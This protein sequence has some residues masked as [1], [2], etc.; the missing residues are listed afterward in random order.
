MI[1]YFDTNV[2][3]HLEQRHG[4]TDW[5][6]FRLERAIKLEHI[7]LIFSFL[8]IEEI[9]FIAESKPE[10]A[11][12]QLGLILKLAGKHLFVR[13]QDEIVRSDIR[14]Y[15]QRKPYQ[16]PFTILTPD[17]ESDILNMMD[18]PAHHRE[19]FD[20]IVRESRAAKE[21][22]MKRNLRSQK[23]LRP[24]AVEIG[25]KQYPFPRYLADNAGWV[26]EGLAQRAGALSSVK[27]RGIKGLLSVK[28]VAVAVGAHLSL[29]YSHQ[30]D[31][32]APS[33]GD[34]RDTL[35]PVLASAGQVFVTNDGKLEKVLSR[36]QIEDFRVMNLRNLLDS[37]PQWI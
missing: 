1:V 30:F 5:D 14:A 17:M 27:R 2:F 21:S 15:A 19:Q 11:M 25:A 4:V 13:G 26:L 12:A 23:K 33:P 6:V 10:R 36:L 7:R 16:T 22:F 3:D 32:H 20:H 35:H 8:N 31:G 9:L 24:M 18:S 28:S 29:L 37:F 34:S